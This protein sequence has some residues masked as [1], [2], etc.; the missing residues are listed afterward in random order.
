[1]SLAENWIAND[2]FLPEG[3]VSGSEHVKKIPLLSVILPGN[4]YC[5]KIHDELVLHHEKSP[6]YDTETAAID[7]C[8][9]FY[10]L[11]HQH[12]GCLH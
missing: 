6:S 5:G 10:Q 11:L 9:S 3:I 4:S 1:M 7:H 8:L 2:Y 12:E